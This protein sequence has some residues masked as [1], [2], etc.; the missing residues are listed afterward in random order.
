MIIFKKIIKNLLKTLR[1][2]FTFSQMVLNVRKCPF[3]D[4]INLVIRIDFRT[5][6]KWIS[7]QNCLARG[8][9]DLSAVAAIRKWGII[10][11]GPDEVVKL[12]E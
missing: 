4:S 2:N 3:C 10:A 11:Y 1:R 9:R 8:P 6:E 5:E 7:C 12:A